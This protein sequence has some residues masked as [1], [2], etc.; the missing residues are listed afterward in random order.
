MQI[1]FRTLSYKEEEITEIQISINNLTI[2]T[3][4]IHQK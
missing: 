1:I 2:Q 3:N 4:I